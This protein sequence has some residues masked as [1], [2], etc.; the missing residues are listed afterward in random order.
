MNAR[1][2]RDIELEE[3]AKPTLDSA[4][5][6]LERKAKIYEKLRKGK[7]GG[8]SDTQ[9]DAL[10]V[11]VNLSRFLYLAPSLITVQSHSLTPVQQHQSTMKQI[12]PMRTR[13]WR[14]LFRQLMYGFISLPSFFTDVSPKDDPIVEYEDEFGRIRTARRSEVPRNLRTE[15]EENVDEDE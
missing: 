9:Y 5:A 12:A 13:V 6:A 14:C 4:R 1:A 11:D 15:P 8:L 10:L 2:S 3:V 7:T